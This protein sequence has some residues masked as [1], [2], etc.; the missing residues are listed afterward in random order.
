MEQV[1]CTRGC[2]NESRHSQ[3]R[4]GSPSP[5]SAPWTPPVELCEIGPRYL[6]IL[7][8]TRRYR[9]SQQQRTSNDEDDLKARLA[10]YNRSKRNDRAEW[11]SKTKDSCEIY[12]NRYLSVHLCP[13]YLGPAL[14]HCTNTKGWRVLKK[15]EVFRR[16]Q[17]RSAHVLCRD[18]STRGGKD[19]WRNLDAPIA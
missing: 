5:P 16:P 12:S 8:P 6:G 9:V 14:R 17:V 11:P 10:F 2:P 13:D 3:E 7:L 15:V 19:G 1:C 4:N 18:Q